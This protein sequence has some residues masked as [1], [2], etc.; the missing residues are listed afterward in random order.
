MQLAVEEHGK[1]IE[2]FYFLKRIELF[3]VATLLGEV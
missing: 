1:G 2:L 3:G